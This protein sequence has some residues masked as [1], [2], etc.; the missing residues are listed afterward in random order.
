V[1]DQPKVVYI[2]TRGRWDR[3]NK[4]VDAWVF[5]G[6][7]VVLWT[8][9]DQEEQALKWREEY[10]G[11]YG[12][13]ESKGLVYTI[14]HAEEPQGIG[15]TRARIVGH[16]HSNKFDAFIMSDDDCY[17]DMQ[18]VTPDALL[19]AVR[20]YPVLACAASHSQ[21]DF[22][23][24]GVLTR[25][26]NEVILAP[27]GI[28][29]QLFA[30][31]T[32]RA[33]EIGNF[34]ED[35]K[36]YEDSEFHRRGVKH[37]YPWAQHTGVRMKKTGRCG[38]PGGIQ[39]Y[40]ALAERETYAEEIRAKLSNRWGPDIIAPPPRKPR[41]NWAKLY[42]IYMPGWRKYSAIHNGDIKEM[43]FGDH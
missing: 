31:N 37:G 41:Q 3:L 17:P 27:H 24:K 30:I 35:I 7:S 9:L 25:R 33:I 15:Y 29:Y 8:E 21:Q 19:E 26:P 13:S 36:V 22:M 12:G 38:D 6:F 18:R 42:D 43:V 14:F 2:P 34:P 32:K 39:D 1:T 16:A 23:L 28:G 4:I 40:M 20:T 10:F 5:W 11:G